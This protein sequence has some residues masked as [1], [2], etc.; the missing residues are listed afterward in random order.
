MNSQKSSVHHVI[1]CV[2]PS[3][4]AFGLSLGF[5]G[6]LAEHLTD[7]Q[8]RC[9]LSTLFA[10]T[11]LFIYFF[12]YTDQTL[13]GR[14]SESAARFLISKIM[15]N[16]QALSYKLFQYTS[17]ALFLCVILLFWLLPSSSCCLGIDSIGVYLARALLIVVPLHAGLSRICVGG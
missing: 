17:L 4:L 11:F 12:I 16:S 14:A 7:F 2:A 15:Q 6:S 13:V 5:S 10:S 8:T 3:A 9:V 1:I